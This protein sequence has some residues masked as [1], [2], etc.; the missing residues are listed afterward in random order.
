MLI[1][2][3]KSSSC[4]AM[5]SRI[6]RGMARTNRQRMDATSER[7]RATRAGRPGAAASGQSYLTAA[8]ERTNLLLILVTRNVYQLSTRFGVCLLQCSLKGSN[9]VVAPNCSTSEYDC[10]KPILHPPPSLSL[11]PSPEC[12]C[13]VAL[14]A[15]KQR[16][17]QRTNDRFVLGSTQHPNPA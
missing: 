2:S 4:N 9:F 11:S 14:S 17:C 15:S 13:L 10:R 3:P 1:H 12:L 5:L 6:S 7:K 16:P 8:P